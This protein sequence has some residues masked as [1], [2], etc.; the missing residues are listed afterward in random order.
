MITNKGERVCDKEIRSLS[1]LWCGCRKPATVKVASE[2]VSYME[3]DYCARH[4]PKAVRG[5]RKARYRHSTRT[6]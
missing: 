5:A 1:G 3:L 4:A 2:V 6:P